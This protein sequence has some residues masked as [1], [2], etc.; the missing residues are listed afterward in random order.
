[1]EEIILKHAPSCWTKS[2]IVGQYELS[3]N[4]LNDISAEVKRAIRST[5]LKISS[6]KRYQNVYDYGQVLIREQLLTVINPG[7]Q[8]YRVR[9]FFVLAKH[10][11][12]AGLDYNLDYRRI[13]RCSELT[14]RKEVAPSDSSEVLIV[15]QIITDNLNLSSIQPKNN[16]D[17]FIDYIVEF[18]D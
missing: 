11:L 5:H 13:G 14:F 18:Q 15:V 9:R 2:T 8:Y 16:A 12:T 3:A 6:I 4:E 7:I 10:R 17:Y 1:M